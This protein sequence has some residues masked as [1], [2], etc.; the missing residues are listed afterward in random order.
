MLFFLDTVPTSRR[1]STEPLAMAAPHARRFHFSSLAGASK[2]ESR[3][4]RLEPTGRQPRDRDGAPD[5]AGR[6]TP[7][8]WTGGET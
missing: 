3:L 7:D 4:T 1:L 8:R 6:S 2:P 5:A